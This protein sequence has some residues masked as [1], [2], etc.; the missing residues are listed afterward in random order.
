M[1]FVTPTNVTNLLWELNMTN[2]G[3]FTNRKRIIPTNGKGIP[4]GTF[5]PEYDM[6]R[7]QRAVTKNGLSEIHDLSYVSRNT[8]AWHWKGSVRIQF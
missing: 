1:K 7:C 4:K 3:Y 5:W 8:F 2:S 6:P